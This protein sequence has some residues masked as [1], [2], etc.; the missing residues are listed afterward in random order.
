MIAPERSMMRPVSINVCLLCVQTYHAPV[1][2]LAD[3]APQTPSHGLPER[4]CPSNQKRFEAFPCYTLI[5]QHRAHTSKTKSKPH[6]SDRVRRK[7]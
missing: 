3:F 4:R 7:R 1:R 5:L 2:S 6:R